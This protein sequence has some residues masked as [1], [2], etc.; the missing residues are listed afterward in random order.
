[1]K[2]VTVIGASPQFIKA[3]TVSWAITEVNIHT[4]QYFDSNEAV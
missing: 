4:G 2:I 3:E 1:M